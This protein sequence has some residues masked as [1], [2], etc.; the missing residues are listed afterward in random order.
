MNLDTPRE[1][2]TK[3]ADTVTDT[4][5]QVGTKAKEYT[6]VAT[7]SIKD[8]TGTAQT[9][10]TEY[11]ETAM[12]AVTDTATM[13]LEQ[14]KSFAERGLVR[15]K[16]FQLGE[17]NVG[18]RAQATV[19]SVSEHIDVEGISEGVKKARHQMEGA[20]GTWVETFR[21][22]TKEAEPAKKPAAKK[23]AAKKTTAKAT[24]AK[25]PAAKKTTAKATTAKKTTA[26]ASTTKKSA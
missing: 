12:G 1:A 17:K 8:T 18:E 2:V 21:P 4:T 15:I 5:T 22:S 25:K 13:V 7:E 10:V 14:T 26:K 9:K 24:T 3:A 23:P 11:G 19:E 20:V 16:E 6:D